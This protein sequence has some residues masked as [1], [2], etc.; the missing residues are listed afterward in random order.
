MWHFLA[1]VFLWVN[2]TTTG[3]NWLHCGILWHFTWA[4]LAGWQ[5][6]DVHNNQGSSAF[7]RHADHCLRGGGKG[8]EWWWGAY[9]WDALVQVSQTQ[10]RWSCGDLGWHC[11]WSFLLSS[12][13]CKRT[14]VSNL[15]K[16]RSFRIVFTLLFKSARHKSCGW[17]RECL[18]LN[19][20]D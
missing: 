18:T 8:C 17:L 5:S 15:W 10:K 1:G 4:Q 3:S 20:E 9:L 12:A 7:S 6:A 19:G 11:G 2:L 16:D 14:E 13:L